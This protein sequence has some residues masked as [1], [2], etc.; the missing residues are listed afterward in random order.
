MTGAGSIIAANYLYKIAKPDGL[1]IGHYLG[2]I[3]L[4]QLLA[5]P[6]H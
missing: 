1:T 3:A 5:K 4:Q 2:G 6:G